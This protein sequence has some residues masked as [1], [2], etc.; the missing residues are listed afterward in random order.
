VL[1]SVAAARS[2]TSGATDIAALNAGYR[3]AFG[4]GALFALVAAAVGA[5]LIPVRTQAEADASHA[6]GDDTGSVETP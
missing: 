1:A 5:G 3:L 4:V 6:E 2:G